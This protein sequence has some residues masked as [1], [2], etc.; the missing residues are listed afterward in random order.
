MLILKINDKRYY[1]LCVYFMSENIKIQS[2]NI[3]SLI[4]ISDYIVKNNGKL[5]EDIISKIFDVIS[6]FFITHNKLDRINGYTSNFKK[7]DSSNNPLIN[8]REAIYKY[9]RK[10]KNIKTYAKDDININDGGINVNDVYH[11]VKIENNEKIK[12]FITTCIFYF[13]DSLHCDKKYSVGFDFEFNQRKIALCQIGLYPNRKHKYIFIIDPNIIG[14]SYLDIMIE[15]LFTSNL[16]RIVHGADSLDIPYI[17]EELFM[18]DT[19][20]IIKFTKNVIDTRFLCEYSKVFATDTNK[21]CSIYDAMLFFKTITKEKYDELNKIND[22]MGPI[23]D[24]NW[25]IN[26]MSSYNLKYAAYDVLYLKHFLEDIMKFGNRNNDLKDNYRFV[27]AIERFVFLEKYNIN[28]IIEESKKIVDPIN[29]FLIKTKNG[30]KTLINIYNSIVDNVYIESLGLKIKN[31]FDINYFKGPLTFLIKRI[32]YSAITESS[33]VYINKNQKFYDKITFKEIYPLL[34]KS[35]LG[36]I[37]LLCEKFYNYSRIEL[38][39]LT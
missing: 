1:F 11:I 7:I 13:F 19:D 39:K 30:N 35:N 21:K 36:I 15:T 25:N 34:H 16:T 17:F 23:Q 27:I 33:T 18:K 6:N 28:D 4:N 31:L 37:V 9:I 20:R 29:N 22:L 32:V 38:T 14:S 5:D 10:I 3:S 2:Q 26:K 12:L 8:I 24:V